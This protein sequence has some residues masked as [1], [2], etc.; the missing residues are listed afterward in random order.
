MFTTVTFRQI[1]IPNKAGRHILPPVN[2]S[3]KVLK[4]YSNSGGGARSFG[5]P[6]LDNFFSRGQQAVFRTVMSPSNQPLLT[7]EDLP[8]GRPPL[9]TNAVGK[10]S[11]KAEATPRT[12]NVGD[13]ITLTLTVSGPPYLSAFDLPELSRRKTLSDNFKIPTER[14]ASEV[15][16]DAVVF[17]Q[18]IR[19]RHDSVSEIPAIGLP[20]F[21][22]ESGQFE[23][24][25]TQP[26]ALEVS[27]TK[28]ITA[29]DAVG[30]RA[31]QRGRALN[32]QRRGIAHNYHGPHVLEPQ[33]PP[34]VTG[35]SRRLRLAFLLFFPVLY[36]L[37]FAVVRLRRRRLDDPARLR[38]RRAFR[39]F[40]NTIEK[41]A[42]RQDPERRVSL[43]Y[44]AVQ[45]YLGNKLQLPA[46]A[47]TF[48][49]IAAR[50]ADA[51]VDSDTRDSLRRLMQSFE[52]R[53]FGGLPVAA[54]K[55]GVLQHEAISTITAIDRCLS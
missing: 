36:G 17:T 41:T 37:L 42:A 28:T 1:V 5:D 55:A 6:F 12:V 48:D 29:A 20:Y 9:F 7:V 45:E 26:I 19:A 21:D 50:L 51:G 38:A 18:T 16:E 10:Y 53:R 22:P 33:P 32:V 23:I 30:A 14:A 43:L 54:D 39:A 52:A 8:G 2:V 13:P 27:P 24:A 34:G 35:F 46:G 49:D 40:R 31:Q 44:D 47:I 11:I 4:G 25:A 15:G 3:C